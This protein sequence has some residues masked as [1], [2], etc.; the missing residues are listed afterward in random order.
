[1]EG[2]RRI[3][4]CLSSTSSTSLTRPRRRPPPHPILSLA[5]AVKGRRDDCPAAR[6]PV[7]ENG[8]EGRAAL[9]RPEP[10]SI[11]TI[12]PSNNRTVGPPSSLAAPQPN[13]GSEL[14]ASRWW[15]WW[16]TQAGP[17]PTAAANRTGWYIIP[18]ATSRPADQVGGG[19][20]AKQQA[21][22]LG[23]SSGILAPKR[24]CTTSNRFVASR[25]DGQGPP[26]DRMLNTKLHYSRGGK[27]GRV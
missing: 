5:K 15:W 16:K 10:K 9:Q 7:S 18:A 1:M 19:P 22:V 25:S 13:P 12:S 6:P 17:A 3:C 24:I 11:V 26:V 4:H 2:E 21:L 27:L 20:L 8:G 14:P 23:I